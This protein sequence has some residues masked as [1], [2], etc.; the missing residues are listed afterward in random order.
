MRV[1]RE[2]RAE[3]KAVKVVGDSI[4]EGAMSWREVDGEA[5][6]GE[7]SVRRSLRPTV[8]GMVLGSSR[9][10]YTAKLATVKK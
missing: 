6:G 9:T 3:W 10:K 7:R 2:M 1:S 5:E 8:R 4:A